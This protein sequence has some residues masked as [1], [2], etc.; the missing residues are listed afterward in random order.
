MRILAVLTLFLTLNFS[1][2]AQSP[3]VIQPSLRDSVKYYQKLSEN[4]EN[5]AL[6]AAR[7]SDSGRLIAARLQQLKAHSK[8]YTAFMLFTE[9]S[10]AD[11]SK[12][13]AAIEQDGFSPLSG[14]V[15]RL[16]FGISHKA[17]DGILI[18][19]NYAVLGF[20]RSVEAGNSKIKANFSNLFELELG[21]AIINSSRFDVYPYAG[22]SLRTDNLVYSTPTVINP[23]YHSI[24]SL[25]GDNQSAH[26]SNYNLGYEAGLGIDYMIYYN[27]KNNGGTILF[28]K[29]GTDGS[30]AAETYKIATVNYNSGIH[31][32]AWIAE[33]GFKFFGR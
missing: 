29:F 10:A 6:E 1:L 15:W 28:G 18:D 23:G 31:Y 4:F 11:F 32:G 25:I 27:K 3:L 5:R 17:Y 7:Q 30:F 2:H 16:G 33:L 21:Y 8:S 26:A 22:L 9:V 19:F 20:N 14:P 24:A 12:L 13:N